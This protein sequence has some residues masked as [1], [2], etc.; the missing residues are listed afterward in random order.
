MTANCVQAFLSQQLAAR[1]SSR[2]RSVPPSLSEEV[3]Q[4]LNQRWRE[5][6][7]CPATPV[8]PRRRDGSFTPSLDPAC[9]CLR[10]QFV[11][12]ERA[13]RV[14]VFESGFA[15]TRRSM[16]GTEI[17]PRTRPSFRKKRHTYQSRSCRRTI[18]PFM[19]APCS[20]SSML[21]A[22]LRPGRRPG[23]RALTTPPRGT[24]RALTRWWLA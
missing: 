24:C 14:H 11:Q 3:S 22:S 6:P 2:R 5:R 1:G 15:G 20:A 21:F 17:G 23:V 4:S 10:A 19:L 8:T 9:R 18:A 7:R 13:A 16:S 12:D